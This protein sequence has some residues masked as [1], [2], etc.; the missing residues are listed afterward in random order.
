[1]GRYRMAALCFD[2][3]LR[4]DPNNSTLWVSKAAV[5]SEL[6]DY[7]ASLKS[8]SKPRGLMQI[9]PLRCSARAAS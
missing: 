2:S 9:T 1:M 6:E 3:A 8:L 5:Q 7:E 4:L